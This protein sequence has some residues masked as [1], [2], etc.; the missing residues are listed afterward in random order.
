MLAAQWGAYA[1]SIGRCMAMELDG[2]EDRM[3]PIA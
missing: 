2:E 3:R 1:A